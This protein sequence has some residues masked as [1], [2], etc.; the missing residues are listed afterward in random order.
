MAVSSG[1]SDRGTLIM[2]LDA[3]DFDRILATEGVLAAGTLIVR[4]VPGFTPVPGFSWNI[5]RSLSNQ[6]VDVF[7]T[8]SLPPRFIYS[9]D[10]SVISVT[11]ACTS[12]IDVDGDSDS[13]DIIAFFGAF[14]N[15]DLTADTDGDGDA[16]SDDIIAYFASF[17]TGC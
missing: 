7:S 11:F 17:E 4:L 8:I 14:E 16:D 10:S 3:A 15:G 9:S 1:S 6:L 2:D 12:D 5:V 13:D